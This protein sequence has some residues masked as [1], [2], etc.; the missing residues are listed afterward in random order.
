M[1]R[2]HFPV[3]QQY[4]YANTAAFGLMSEGLQEWRQ[5]HDL[6]YL[7]GGGRMKIDSLSIISE[8]R[9]TIAKFFNCDPHWVALLPNFSIGLNFL[10]EG[11]DNKNRVLLIEDDYPSVNWPFEKRGFAITYVKRAADLEDR[12][13]ALLAEEKTDILAL[14][15]VQWLDGLMID[16]DFISSL[17]KKYPELLI[18]ADGTQFCGAFSLDFS[19]SG[20]DV[21]GA[22][23]YKW[24]LGGTGNGFLLLNEKISQGIHPKVTGFNASGANLDRKDEIPFSRQFEPGH[25]DSLCF[26]SLNF[27]LQFLLQLGMPSIEAH[28]NELSLMAKEVF[29]ARGLL[30][31]QLLSRSRHSTIFN[32][33]GD[34]GLYEFLL[35]ND[36]MCS[37]RGGGIRLAFHAYNN[38][39]DIEN[40][41][42]LIDRYDK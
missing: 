25:L 7:V 14:S 6:D 33:N 37:Q 8:T 10:L 20:I 24:M 18:I 28:N 26:G 16:M 1:I 13:K 29:G 39:Q 23:G 31:Q 19:S 30:S 41:A 32:I 9:Q 11:I 22:S 12:I 3:L 2:K 17:K 15:L 40:I 38:K 27:S 34:A 42:D 5:D 36:V 35:A 21:L 4:I